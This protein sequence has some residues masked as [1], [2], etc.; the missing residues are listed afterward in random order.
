[1]I[2]LH[3]GI[4]SD[5]NPVKSPWHIASHQPVHGVYRLYCRLKKKDTS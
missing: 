2:N 3:H 4:K 5:I 1:M